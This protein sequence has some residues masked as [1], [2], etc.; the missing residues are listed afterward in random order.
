MQYKIDGTP[1]PVVICTL[2]A[3]ET[4]DDCAL[5]LPGLAGQALPDYL[6]GRLRRPR[7]LNELG[8]KYPPRLKVRSHLIQSRD[9]HMI[10][11]LH[12][13]ALLQQPADRF[14]RLSFQAG[15]HHLAKVPALAR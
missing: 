14:S 12:G 15:L 11:N 2:E 13:G 8:E 6:K 3:G 1:L 7:R 10:H 9:Q 4:M 5:L